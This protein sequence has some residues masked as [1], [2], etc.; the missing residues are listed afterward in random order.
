MRRDSVL[1]AR[2]HRVHEV[3]HFAAL[4]PITP[5]VKELKHLVHVQTLPAL[6]LP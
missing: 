5:S 1:A 3:V 2:K 4:Q 6:V